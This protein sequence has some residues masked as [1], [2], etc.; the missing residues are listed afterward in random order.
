MLFNF[1]FCRKEVEYGLN[2]GPNAMGLAYHLQKAQNFDERCVS[3]KTATLLFSYR[4]PL[5]RSFQFPGVV[6]LHCLYPWR[7]TNPQMVIPNTFL[8]FTTSIPFLRLC[9][10]IYTCLCTMHTRTHVRS[11]S[12]TFSA[13]KHKV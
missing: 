8:S 7:T 2:T 6:D 5:R 1:F 4:H 10:S 12:S 13:A 3:F 9:V 11:Y